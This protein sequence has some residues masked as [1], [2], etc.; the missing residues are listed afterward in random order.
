MRLLFSL[1]LVVI[2]CFLLAKSYIYA[3]DVRM[4]PVKE[5]QL[6]QNIRRT[7]IDNPEHHRYITQAVASKLEGKAYKEYLALWQ[8]NRNNFNANLRLGTVAKKYYW[9][10]GRP[11]LLEVT[12]K[13]AE[14]LSIL[15]TAK[16]RLAQAVQLQPRSFEA[17]L[18][19]GE[20][21]YFPIGR[22]SDG[23][24]YLEKAI[25]LNPKSPEA[26]AI[27]GD[28]IGYPGNTNEGLQRAIELKSKAI[29]LDANY[30]FPHFSLAR[31]YVFMKRF[32][33]ADAALK[34]YLELSPPATANNPNVKRIRQSIT[35][36]TSGRN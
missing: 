3:Q 4:I 18:E 35:D 15:E 12:Q 25:E 28:K 10:I 11:N 14:A 20:L 31:Q 32:K 1:H 16:Q 30:A 2:C 6:L 23:L 7:A 19:W 27:L 5:Q 8:A 29:K 9:R 24:R 21:L 17:N 33:E 36:G 26:H 13:N 22:T 34:K